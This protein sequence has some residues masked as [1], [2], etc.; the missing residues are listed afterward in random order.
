MCVCVR[1]REIE[2]EKER[3][4]EKERKLRHEIRF[5]STDKVSNEPAVMVLSV[6]QTF[7]KAKK[8]EFRLDKDTNLL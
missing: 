4:K 5:S 6:L 1:E 7:S 2:S 8:H 3:E